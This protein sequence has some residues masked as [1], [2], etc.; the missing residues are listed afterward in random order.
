MATKFSLLLLASAS[1]SL[2]A[3]TPRPA[4]AC[5]GN[6]G[7]MGVTVSVLDVNTGDTCA[8]LGGGTLVLDGSSEESEKKLCSSKG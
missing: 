4:S 1:L 6:I 8:E 3:T 7:P 2:M 5:T